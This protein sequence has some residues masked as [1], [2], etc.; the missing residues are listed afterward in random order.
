MINKGEVFITDF[1]LIDGDPMNPESTDLMVVHG[2][3]EV[4]IRVPPD[5]RVITGCETSSLVAAVGYRY[6]MEELLA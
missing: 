6:E 4:G 1:T 2:R 3:L 5:W